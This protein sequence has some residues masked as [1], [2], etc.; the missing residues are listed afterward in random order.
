M[1]FP[2]SHYRT[3]KHFY[4]AE[5]WCR[6][7]A[8]F[9]ALVSYQRLVECFPAVLVPWAA[10]LRTR[11]GV[12]HGIAFIDSLP[13]PVCHHRRIHSHRVFAG[14]APRAR[15]SLDWFYGLKLHFVI[16]EQG[17]LLAFRLTPGNV[18]DRTP[19]PS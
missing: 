10:Y 11:L 19:L 12:T 4:V 14:V 5:V 17:E 6:W 18:D 8:E 1:A 16:N 9:P 15:S 2:I 7:R 3:F 13:L